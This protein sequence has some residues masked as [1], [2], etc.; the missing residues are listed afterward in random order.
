MEDFHFPDKSVCFD[1]TVDNKYFNDFCNY[2]KGDIK[3][4]DFTKIKDNTISWTPKT[5]ASIPILI[6]ISIQGEG[7]IINNPYFIL[8]VRYRSESLCNCHFSSP[9]DAIEYIN[10]NIRACRARRDRYNEIW[11]TYGINV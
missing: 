6:F 9:I 2:Y 1:T 3:P 7:A 11:V 8:N 4:E 10:A 5:K